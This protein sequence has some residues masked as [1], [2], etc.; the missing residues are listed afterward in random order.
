MVPGHV[1]GVPYVDVRLYV[2]CRY[3]VT[4]KRGLEGV[5]VGVLEGGLN[6]GLKWVDQRVC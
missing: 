1:V 5:L 3:N 2:A 6:E 4:Y